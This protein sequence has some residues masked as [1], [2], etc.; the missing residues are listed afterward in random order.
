NP[1]LLFVGT[2]WGL[3]FTV[4]GGKKWIRLRGN[5]PTIPVRD[6]AIQERENDL[7]LATFGRGFYILDDYSPLRTLAQGTFDRDGHIFPTKAA[8][9]EVPEQGRARGS[10]GEALWMAENAPMGAMITYWIKDAPRSMR[11][12]RQETTRAAEAKNAS[13]RYPTQQELTAEADEEAPQT[14]MTITDDKGRVVRRL[15]VPGGRGIHRYVWNLRTTAPTTGGGGFGGGG[16][17][18]PDADPPLVPTSTGGGSF[19]QPGTYRVALSRRIDGAVTALGEPQT[20]TVTADPGVTLTPA[21]RTAA[22]EY[23]GQVDKLQR[24]FTGALE[25][26]NN[27]RTKTQAMQRA[28]VDSPADIKMLDQAR[29]FDQRVVAILRALRGDETLR[30]LESGDP[31]SIQ[32]RVNSAVQGARGLTGAPTGTQQRN[33]Q[34]ANEDLTAQINALRTLEGELR[35]FEQQ[36]EAAG[37]PYTPGRV[38]GVSR[39]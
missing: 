31:T 39:D 10:Q 6:L 13:P 21:Q 4:D 27:L 26:A 12:R 19:V 25:L 8:M 36:L 15:A 22:A 18:G 14:F 3:F 37:V 9:I 16:G 20:L 11:Q 35:K 7:V 1:N 24:G 38:P 17:G 34:I 28:L 2:E 23:H 33:Y 29:Q 32:D 30:G 5:L